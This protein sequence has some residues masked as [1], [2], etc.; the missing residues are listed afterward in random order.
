MST[1]F[2]KSY[3]FDEASEARYRIAI[4]AKSLSFSDYQVGGWLAWN[5]K[6]SHHRYLGSTKNVIFGLICGLLAILACEFLFS[7]KGVRLNFSGW[8]NGSSDWLFRARNAQVLFI[9]LCAFILGSLLRSFV[10]K[11]RYRKNLQRLYQVND[12]IQGGCLLELTEKGVRCAN[13]KASSCISWQKIQGV[14]SHNDIDYILVE[15]GLFLWIP[16]ALEGYPRDEMLAF[17]EAKRTE[18]TNNQDKIV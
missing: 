3:F 14:I 10:F 13:A 6:K 8:Y 12:S 9:L 18:V 7:V 2:D 11:R 4:P 1:E 16:A 15:E 5:K 17:I